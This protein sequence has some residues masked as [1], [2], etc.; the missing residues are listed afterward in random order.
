M[1]RKLT[2]VEFCIMNPPADTQ[3]KL[4]DFIAPLVKQAQN[5][6]ALTSASSSGN[7]GTV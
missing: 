1:V 6:A 5:R 2:G 7:W 3:N 4:R